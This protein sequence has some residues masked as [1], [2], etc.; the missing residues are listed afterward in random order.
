MFSCVINQFESIFFVLQISSPVSSIAPA[1]T[2]LHTRI[3]Q[4]NNPTLHQSWQNA[5]ISLAV[6]I[7]FMILTIIISL[8]KIKQLKDQLK[9]LQQQQQQEE[10][11]KFTNRL[12]QEPPHMQICQ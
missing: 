6:I 5:V 1:A 8:M 2:T 4:Q 11:T 9:H 12:E 7:F 10:L 3:D